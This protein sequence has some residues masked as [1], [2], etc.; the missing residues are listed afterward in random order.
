MHRRPGKSLAS[1]PGIRAHHFRRGCGGA[2][3]GRLDGRQ[4]HSGYVVQPGYERRRQLEGVAGALGRP[5]PVGPARPGEAGSRAK[6]R[7][8]GDGV[9][10]PP[11]WSFSHFRRKG[12]L[13]VNGFPPFPIKGTF[14]RKITLERAFW[15]VLA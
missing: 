6:G 11:R 13:N 10:E 7:F 15:Y 2:S 1:G 14:R 8:N 4:V 5:Q 3:G 12:N 9:R